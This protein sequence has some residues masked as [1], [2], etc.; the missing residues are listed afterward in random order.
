MK[1]SAKEIMHQVSNKTNVLKEVSETER[2]KLQKIQLRILIDVQKA[3]KEIGV[4]CVLCGGSCLG[5]IRH[6]G[7]IPWDDDIDIS[8]FRKDWNIFKKHFEDI[9][10]D[11]YVLESPNYGNKDTKYP[12][13]TIYLKNTEMQNLLDVNLPYCKGIY[14]DVFV[15]EN[16]PDN[17][18][19]Q[20]MDAIVTAGMKYIAN[21]MLFYK[22]PSNELK[23]FFSVTFKSRMYYQFRRL[24]GFSFSFVSHKKFL[25]WYDKFVSRHSDETE[26]VTIPTGTHLYLGEM[27]SR[28][29][30]LPYSKAMFCGVEVNLPHLPEKYL[31]MMYGAN[32]MEIPPVKDR[33]SHFVYSLKFP[34]DQVFID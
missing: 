12:W 27:L 14:I 11:K 15:I 30:W 19:V 10:G 20:K 29:V 31:T 6:H 2:R 5:A 3:C 26:M 28:K 7:F 34:D 18:V 9:L 16:V 4:E 8:L 32:Y 23:T 17:K 24:L 25:K 13:S 1:F 22:Y 21:S 33:I